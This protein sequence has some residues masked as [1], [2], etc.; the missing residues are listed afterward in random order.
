MGD[1]FDN[2]QILTILNNR[3]RHLLILA[4]VG[5]AVSFFISSPWIMKPKYKAAAVVY[6]S[7][8]E[9]YGE[10]S[11]TEQLLQLLSSGEINKAMIKKFDLGNHY[12]LDTTSKYYQ[13]YVNKTLLENLSVEKT[14]YE[15][16]SIS[17]I[18]HDPYF[19]YNMTKEMMN[20]LNTTVREMHRKKYAETLKVSQDA[21]NKKQHEIDS[22]ANLVQEYRTKYNILDYTVQVK[23]ATRKYYRSTGSDGKL[24]DATNMLR[25]LEAKGEGY[26]ATTY[27]LNAAREALVLLKK[28]VDFSKMQLSKELSY[29]DIVTAPTVPDKKFWPVRWVIVTA[30]TLSTVLAGLVFF[31]FADHTR[32]KKVV[33]KDVKTED[34]PVLS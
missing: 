32:K 21:Y 19:A 22:M 20:L 7:N 1:F 34:V 11:T 28:D 4:L 27:S 15:A 18:D 24:A 2:S 8:L 17:V 14:E 12:D 29:F 26:I 30:F 31:L 16:V 5:I 25:T 3:K 10:E 13:T 9:P 23:E 6:P 33:I